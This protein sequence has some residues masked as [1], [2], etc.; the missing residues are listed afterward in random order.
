[1]SEQYERP[2]N[3]CADRVLVVISVERSWAEQE[4]VMVSLLGVPAIM[5]GAFK[6][7]LSTGALERRKFLVQPESTISMSQI[8]M[9]LV[10]KGWCT[11]LR[12]SKMLI[13][14]LSKVSKCDTPCHFLL[15]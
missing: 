14:L 2:G 13:L 7:L 1:M 12:L 9:L 15:F 6:F 5:M 8:G 11:I 10:V 3:K 4:E